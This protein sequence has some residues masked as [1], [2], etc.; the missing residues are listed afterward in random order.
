MQKKDFDPAQLLK[1]FQKELKEVEIYSQVND[2][3]YYQEDE[4][5]I[6]TLPKHIYLFLGEPRTG[7]TTLA[8]FT[9]ISRF[10]HF[11]DTDGYNEESFLKELANDIE[12]FLS[13]KQNKIL[14]IIIGKYPQ[15]NEQVRE[16]LQNYTSEQIFITVS[17]FE[18]L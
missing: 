11:I 10:V 3:F 8:S 13:S 7:K 6:E 9:S 2:Q 5:L 17:Q 16:L 18:R 12:A 15:M 14:V 1:L 4:A